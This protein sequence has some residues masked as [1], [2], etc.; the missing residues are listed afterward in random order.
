MEKV[1]ML[2]AKDHLASLVKEVQ[3]G[4]EICITDCDKEVAMLI[5]IEEY[6]SYRNYLAF[7]K[8]YELKKEAPL[9]DINEIKAMRDEGRK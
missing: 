9:G 5:S 4:K 3:E 8:L 2:D 1:G 7:K 6:E